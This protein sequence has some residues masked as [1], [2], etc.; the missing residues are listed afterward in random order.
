MSRPVNLIADAVY[1][2]RFLETNNLNP[3][4][5]AELKALIREDV[6]DGR[7]YDALKAQGLVA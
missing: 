1:E 4:R 7:E 5:V 3:E 2:I 6:N